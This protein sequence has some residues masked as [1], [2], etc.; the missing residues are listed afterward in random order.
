MLLVGEGRQLKI[1]DN[2]KSEVLGS[3]QVFRSQSIHG[4]QCRWDVEQGHLVCLVWGGRAITILHLKLDRSDFCTV[5][6]PEELVTDD[7]ISDASFPP[8][9]THHPGDQS[10]LTRAIFLSSHNILYTLLV[11]PS[12]SSQGQ[13]QISCEVIAAGPTSVLYSAHVVVL[14]SGEALIAAGTVFGEVLVWSADLSDVRNRSKVVKPAILLKT[15]YGHE[16]SVFG[17]RISEPIRTVDHRSS[18]RMLATCSDDRT[19]RLWDLSSTSG[20]VTRAG[21]RTGFKSQPMVREKNIE[22]CV[23]SVM[24][25]GSRIW[26]LRFLSYSREATR[27]ISFGEDSTCHTW[28]LMKKL[29]RGT[30]SSTDKSHFYEIQHDESYIYHIGKNIWA[31]AVDFQD[32]DVCLILTGGAD[33]RIVSYCTPSADIQGWTTDPP[34]LRKFV[35]KRSSTLFGGPKSNP[36]R[37]FSPAERAFLAIQGHWRLYRVLESAI[38][39]YPSGSFSGIATLTQRPPTDRNYDAEYLYAEEGEL[40][41]RQGLTMR[42]SRRYIYRY[43]KASDSITTWFVK[44][45]SAASV[46]YLFHQVKFDSISC[47]RRK[48]ETLPTN[49]VTTA[50]GHHLCVD[51]EYEAEYEFRYKATS[52]R[53]WNLKYIVKGPKK[54]YTAS[55]NYKRNAEVESSSVKSIEI[56]E[57][58]SASRNN[59]DIDTDTFK[60]YSWIGYSEFI[61]T[62]ASGSIL[63]GTLNR[64]DTIESPPLD[65]TRSKK[66]KI[67]SW[68]LVDQIPDLYSFSI[69]VSVSNDTVLL[70]AANGNIY[71]YQRSSQDVV[72]FSKLPR[73]ISG[74][75]AEEHENS[76]RTTRNI[77]VIACCVGDTSAYYYSFVANNATP[78][79]IS[80][81][82]NLTLPHGFIVSSVCL[83]AVDDILVLGSRSGALCYYDRSS[84]HFTNPVSACGCT[85]QVHGNDAITSIKIVPKDEPDVLG[86][87]ILTTGR[88]GNYALHRVHTRRTGGETTV[89]L[90]RLHTTVPPFGPNIEGACF[91][92]E[93]Q[94]LLLWGFRSTDFVVWNETK[95]TEVMT[96][97]CGGSHRTWAYLPSNDRRNGGAFIWTKASVCN[98][99]AQSKASHQ[100]LQPGGHGREIKALAICPIQTKLDSDCGYL[101]AT[102]AEDT[103]IRI[104]FATRGNADSSQALRCLGVI[105]QH[106]TGI[107]QL[108]WSSDGQFLFS[109]AGR[110]EFYVWQ[111][112]R[113]PCLDIGFVCSSQCPKVTEESDLR[114]MSFDVETIVADVNTAYDKYIV[115]IVYSDSTVRVRK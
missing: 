58:D 66:S 44:T 89:Y 48:D 7:W 16:G 90:E 25:H 45:D 98:V 50:K 33:G 65:T 101:V 4:I 20:K 11:E 106:N 70:G 109:A 95:R 88:D 3:L 56:A 105:S 40:T 14:E 57:A 107:Q 5:I 108:Q 29:M 63:L 91:D 41:T 99:Q 84:F 71:C 74:L 21:L 1:Y 32:E 62:T 24:G 92:I 42:G 64:C 18:T 73:K 67:I 22:Q 36:S 13:Y 69:A 94:D 34:S 39:T 75:F 17:V 78:K 82:G 111:V 46:E 30:S 55:A 10:F 23:A 113:V 53:Q 6:P 9:T 81:I 93:N 77:A 2:H 114:I 100:V 51:D 38:S 19:I 12:S 76:K 60:T 80:K 96:V 115:S 8:K 31:A 86:N 72:T 54:D 37:P 27:C 43:Q 103:T 85:R 28:Q 15:L 61:A 87:F 97:P 79:D 35:M 52:L 47:Q 59:S 83:T 104:S 26:G 102:G 49:L 110:E 112:H 68:C